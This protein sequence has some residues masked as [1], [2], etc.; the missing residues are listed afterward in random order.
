MLKAEKF[1]SNFSSWSL[2]YQVTNR[3]KRIRYVFIV[4]CLDVK[5]SPRIKKT[6]GRAWKQYAFPLYE[7]V[8]N[9]S[10]QCICNVSVQ[11]WLVHYLYYCFNNN[12]HAWLYDTRALKNILSLPIPTS[13]DVKIYPNIFFSYRDLDAS[14]TW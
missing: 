9:T 4:T 11:F 12:L 3:H 6:Q 13:I 2:F 10:Y 1:I 7:E 14:K 8:I 5:M